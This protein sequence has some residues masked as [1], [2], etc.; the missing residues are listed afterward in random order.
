MKLPKV[1]RRWVVLGVVLVLVFATLRLLFQP[2]TL[3][4]YRVLDPQ[5]LVVLG[6][7]APG[8]WTSVS[9]VS[10]TES[11]VTISVDKF[12]FQLPVPGTTI[13]AP[14]ELGVQL[15]A[16]LAGRTVI[17]GGTGQEVPPRAGE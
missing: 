17:D 6:H 1:R 4:S 16:P 15:E 10:E 11:T 9:S 3:E 14:L 7:G 8:A 5:T 12:T 13:G 2:L